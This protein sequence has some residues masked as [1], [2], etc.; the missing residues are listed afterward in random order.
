MTRAAC[1]ALNRHFSQVPFLAKHV[2]ASW[3]ASPL[4]SLKVFCGTVA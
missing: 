4:V 2:K 1:G 3:C